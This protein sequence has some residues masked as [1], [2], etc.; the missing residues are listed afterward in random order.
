MT[1][2]FRLS[3]LSAAYAQSAP[4]AS[5]EQRV[6][7]IEAYLSNAAPSSPLNTAEC[8]IDFLPKIKL[9]VVLADALAEQAVQAIIGA[10]KTGKIGDGKLFVLPV[11]AAVRIRTEESNEK[12]I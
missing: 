1:K 9:D 7:G 11:E 2:P 12:A 4:A 3:F 5:L 6:A 8:T 10:A